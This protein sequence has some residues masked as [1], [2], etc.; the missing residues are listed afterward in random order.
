MM[1]QQKSVTVDL[2]VQQ[3]NSINYPPGVN[4]IDTCI[5]F[6]EDFLCLK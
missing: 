5:D 2:E 1:M 3:N 6:S 4:T